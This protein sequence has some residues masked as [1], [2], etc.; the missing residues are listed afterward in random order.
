[1][2]LLF[3]ARHFTYFRNFEAAIR[4]LVDR[5]HEVH[6]AAD[7]DEQLGGRA[8]VERLAAA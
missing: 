5:G 4:Q 8:L 1:M 3:V 2:R 7:R 6:L